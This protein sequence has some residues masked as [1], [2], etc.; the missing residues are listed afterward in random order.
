VELFQ[1]PLLVVWV[2]LNPPEHSRGDTVANG[3]ANNIDLFT[4]SLNDGI[5]GI[6]V[7]LHF[8]HAP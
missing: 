5:V 4:E 7:Q 1:Q 8:G 2:R 6:H 3:L